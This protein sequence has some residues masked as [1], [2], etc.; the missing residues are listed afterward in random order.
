MIPILRASFW[1]ACCT[2]AVLS[3]LPSDYLPSAF[4]WWDKA[5]HALAFLAWVARPRLLSQVQ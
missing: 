1:V 4:N 2:A 3:L 5:Q